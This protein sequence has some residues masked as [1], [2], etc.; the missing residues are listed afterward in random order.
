MANGW[1]QLKSKITNSL[2]GGAIGD[3]L[4]A[5]LEFGPGTDPGAIATVTTFGRGCDGM[6][7]DDTQMALFTLEACL[8]YKREGDPANPLIDHV[9]RA[10]RRWYVTQTMDPDRFFEEVGGARGLQ[11]DRSFWSRRAPGN[12]CLSALAGEVAGELPPAAPIN[13][14]KGCGG[15]MRVAPIAW[16]SS[17]PFMDGCRS[18][19]LTHGH[20]DGWLPAG[21]LARLL[22][23]L[24]LGDHL[25]S[26][27]TDAWA[28]VQKYHGASCQTAKLITN[29]LLM[30]NHGER[31][32]TK[33][34]AGWTGDEALAIGILAAHHG[35]REGAMAGFELA[36]NHAGDSDSTGSIA[37]Q[38]MGAAGVEMP[39]ELVEGVEF[40]RLIRGLAGE[41]VAALEG[42]GH[43]Q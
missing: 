17:D 8:A 20:P 6:V 28:C 16:A 36:V 12:T 11:M 3:A 25:D 10:Y 27:A 18:A 9:W 2:I 1:T 13:D 35:I 41:L 23:R 39:A 22:L 40:G 5:P 26:A 15:V 37:G 24:T 32:V 38:I 4:G 19:A 7:T 33:L 21:A 31:D 42:G 34:G 43:E 30:I 14:S 29:A